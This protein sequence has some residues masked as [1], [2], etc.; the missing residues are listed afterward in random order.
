MSP[1]SARNEA[2]TKADF[3]SRCCRKLGKSPESR[4]P[5]H[6]IHLCLWQARS[7]DSFPRE[8]PRHEAAPRERTWAK[9]RAKAKAPTLREHIAAA[10]CRVL[11][12]SVIF[13]G[14]FG[15]SQSSAKI[16]RWNSWH[17]AKAGGKIANQ[18]LKTKSNCDAPDSNKSIEILSHEFPARLEKFLRCLR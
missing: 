14:L 15:F 6:Q 3:D 12:A 9:E 4:R 13:H 10:P 1:R 8:F 16:G 11:L 7:P 18:E 2:R 17:T 5:K